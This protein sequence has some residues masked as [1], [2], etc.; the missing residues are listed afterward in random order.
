M[1]QGAIA[2]L[3]QRQPKEADN[4]AITKRASNKHI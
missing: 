3:E 4:N 2:L 1:R